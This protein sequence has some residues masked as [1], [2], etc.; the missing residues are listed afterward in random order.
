MFAAAALAAAGLAGCGCGAVS[1]AQGE[2]A[3]V[4]PETSSPMGD[5]LTIEGRSWK[6][7][8]FPAMS[9]RVE[10]KDGHVQLI[11]EKVGDKTREDAIK[12]PGA[13]NVEKT[14]RNLDAQL[15]FEVVEAGGKSTLKQVGRSRDFAE[16]RF[17]K[18]P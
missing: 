1:A 2:W 7:T 9:G 4:D 13:V 18:R 5:L 3:R 17:E 12:T 8:G 15:V 14:L 6:M 11:I 10:T 16:L